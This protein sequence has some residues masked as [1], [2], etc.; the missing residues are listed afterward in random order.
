MGPVSYLPGKAAAIPMAR[1]K[2]SII[3]GVCI[4]LSRDIFRLN[5]GS[6]A[7]S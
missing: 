7:L 5:G 2:D 3:L 1:H 6:K 4:V